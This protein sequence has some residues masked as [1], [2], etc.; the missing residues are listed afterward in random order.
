[1]LTIK[2]L[3]TTT[4]KISSNTATERDQAGQQSGAKREGWQGHWFASDFF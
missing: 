4:V 1:M 3:K 2:F